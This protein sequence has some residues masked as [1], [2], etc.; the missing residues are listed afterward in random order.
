[1]TYCVIRKKISSPTFIVFTK[2]YKLTV[3]TSVLQV[4]GRRSDGSFLLSIGVYL[5]K[6]CKNARA[7]LETCSRKNN[8]GTSLLITYF[9]QIPYLLTFKAFLFVRFVLFCFNLKFHTII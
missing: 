8:K 6:N 1:M 7:A 9:A 3:K 2:L 5:L 4:H